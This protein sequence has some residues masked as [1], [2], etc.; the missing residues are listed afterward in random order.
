M[1]Q[2]KTGILIS[3][4]WAAMI[5]GTV[6]AQPPAPAGPQSPAAGRGGGGM[7]SAYPQRPPADPAAIDR[8]R[9]LYSVNCAFC[10]GSDARGG[11]GGPNLIRSQMVLDDKNGEGITPTVQNGRPQNGMPKFNFTA[12]QISDIAA[13][14]HTIPV[15]GRDPARPAGPINIVVG[16]ATAGKAFFDARCGS[17]HSATGDLK[18]IASKTADAKTLQ[19]TW[20]MPNAGRGG[21]GGAPVNVPPATVTVTLA[22]GQ[23]MEGRLVRLDDFLVTLSEADGKLR[24]IPR[25]GDQPRVEVHDPMQAHLNLLPVYTDK[26]IHDVTAYLVTL[27]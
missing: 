26:E 18:G 10:H 11:E 8:G 17:C 21:R 23:K 25:K 12:A 5:T 19:Q 14:I 16:D 15:G 9:G 27:K 4:L 20:I 6:N 22:S 2:G 1:H 24:S 13:F 3:T 7:R